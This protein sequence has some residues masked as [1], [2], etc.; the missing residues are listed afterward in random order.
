MMIRMTILALVLAGTPALAQT[1]PAPQETA[2]LRAED[3]RFHAELTHDVATLDRM[4]APGVTYAHANGALEDKASVLRSFTHIP[5]TAIEPANRHAR[6]LGDTG[7][8]RGEVTRTLPDRTLHD[9]YLAVY[10]RQGRSWQLIDWVS[11]AP[12]PLAAKP[13]NVPMHP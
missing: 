13:G 10:V 5:F 4:T 2:L 12:P 3:E 9:A 7:V 8:V 11:Y 1:V 6:V